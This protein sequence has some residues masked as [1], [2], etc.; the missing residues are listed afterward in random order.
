MK[1][2]D[3]Y[4][5]AQC[6]VV[7]SPNLTTLTKLDILRLLFADEDLELYKERKAEEEAKKEKADEAV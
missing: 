1:K 4:Q 2:S 7:D 5:Y 3:L 6:A